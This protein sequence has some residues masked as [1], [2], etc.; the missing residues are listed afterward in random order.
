M[1]FH[2]SIQVQIKEAVN[3]PHALA[4]FVFCQ[5]TFYGQDGPTVVPPYINPD[6]E[7]YHSRLGESIKGTMKFQHSKVSNI[8][9]K[10]TKN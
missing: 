1:S 2:F 3:L 10:L 7:E 4:H 9:P 5:Y 8:L 6:Q